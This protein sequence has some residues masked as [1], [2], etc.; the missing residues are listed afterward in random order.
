MLYSRH[1]PL[2]L[3]ALAA[4]VSPA[5]AVDQIKSAKA[6]VSGTITEMGRFEVS[7]KRSGGEVVKIPTNEIESIK[8]NGENPRLSLLRSAVQGGRFEEV[9]K[10]CDELSGQNISQVEVKQDLEYYKALA[11][12]RLALGGDGDILAAGSNA[13]LNFVKTN[14]GSYHFLDATE[15]VGDLLVANGKHAMAQEYYG[16][17][18]A[19]PWPDVRMRGAVARGRALQSERKF[20]E[21]L[22]VFDKA[23]ILAGDSESEPVE[24]QKH[25]ALI[26]KAVCLAETGKP[27]EA[28]KMLDKV[29]DQIEPQ[30]REMHAVAYNGLGRCY[31]KAGNAKAAL[32]AYLHTDLMYNTFPATHAEALTNLAELWKELGDAN[33]ATQAENT[34]T[35]R[36]KPA[37]KK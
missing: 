25:A 24:A 33:R 18:E 35:E 3:V 29:I 5:S 19:A 37:A 30:R 1:I 12:S 14:P 26:G 6:L 16:N 9:I 17:L 15:I 32:M 23:A 13:M 36:Y 28:I 10:T 8:F 4:W 2:A 21:A 22:V 27:V 11:L 31:R 34:L 7:I 20:A